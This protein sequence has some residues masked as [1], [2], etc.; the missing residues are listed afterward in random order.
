MR[1]IASP[2]TGY[3]FFRTIHPNSGMCFQQIHCHL[4][5]IFGMRFN[6]EFPDI[7]LYEECRAS[8]LEHNLDLKVALINPTL[9]AQQV[10]AEDAKFE[11]AFTFG[12]QYS[13]RHSKL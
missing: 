5:L 11:S 2:N 12:A 13:Q 10:T 4:H 9:A 3:Q 1:R 8:A 7:Y 6:I